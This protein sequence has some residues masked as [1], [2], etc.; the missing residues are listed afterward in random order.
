MSERTDDSGLTGFVW[1]EAPR[2]VDDTTKL[3]DDLW[4]T[5]VKKDSWTETQQIDP[6]A[7]FVPGYSTDQEMPLLDELTSRDQ[8]V[9]KTH[10]RELSSR[11][12]KPK[13]LTDASTSFF[14][15]IDTSQVATS[16]SSN[17][18]AVFVGDRVPFPG[19][20]IRRIRDIDYYPMNNMIYTTFRKYR[21]RQLS[22]FAVVIASF[23]DSRAAIAD[24]TNYPSNLSEGTNETIMESRLALIDRLEEQVK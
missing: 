12:G 19:I 10:F 3:R 13:S 20:R 14:G 18:R 15:L 5:V 24:W 4:N 11:E 22:S 16:P 9:A 7:L 8:V 23:I 21:E 6:T 2:Q 1:G 17:R